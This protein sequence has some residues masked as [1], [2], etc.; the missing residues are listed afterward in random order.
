MRP[1]CINQLE[2]QVRPGRPACRTD[3]PDDRPTTDARADRNGRLLKQVHVSGAT[4]VR[5]L[6][7][8]P[9]A[10]SVL[11]EPVACDDPIHDRLDLR[12]S[13]KCDVD[14][15]VHGLFPSDRVDTHPKAA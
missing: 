2:V 1:R 14:A 12:P 9:V 10:S 13:R 6:N 4:S 5:V 7:L 15:A 3:L 8:D 11:L